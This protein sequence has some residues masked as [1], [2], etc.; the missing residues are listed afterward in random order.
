MGHQGLGA[1]LVVSATSAMLLLSSGVAQAGTSPNV[2]GQKYSDASSAISGAGLRPVVSTI[3]GDQKA[4]PDCLVAS[5]EAR[6]V[7]PPE[8]SAGSAT[9]E[10]LVSLNCYSAAASAKTP[11]YSAVS[12]EAKAIAAAAK[13]SNSSG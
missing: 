6:T 10:V 8:N 4:W 11:G 5:Q 3:V 1:A 13:A 9:N 12:P 2:V 7:P